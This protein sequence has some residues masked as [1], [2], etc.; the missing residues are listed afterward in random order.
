METAAAQKL[1][2][3][4][5]TRRQVPEQQRVARFAR[6]IIRLMGGIIAEHFSPATISA[7]TGY[8]ELQPVPNLPPAPPQMIPNPQA[9]PH[10]VVPMPGMAQPG[11]SQPQ[12]AGISMAPMGASGAPGLP[13]GGPMP[14]GQPPPPPPPM[15][16]NPAFEQWQ[17]A[18][19]A[20]ANVIAMNAAK[21][22]QFDEAVALIKKDGVTGFR[23]DIESDSTIAADELQDRADRTE[24]IASLL[25]LMQQTVPMAMGNPATAEFAKQLT[26]FGVR[27]FPAARS[28]EESIE[29]F[30]DAI[31]G[32]P[33]PQGK[34][35]GKPGPD[36]QVEHAKIAASMH[37]TDQKAQT[38]RMAIAQRAQQANNQ[39]EIERMK[40]ESE[41]Q[42][43]QVEL[44]IQA[45]E[46]Q[47]R[48][49]V[50]M[51]KIDMRGLPKLV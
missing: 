1:K 29:Q 37:D 34:Q 30:F 3:S 36:P 38:D 21:Q 8:P 47:N 31:G 35:N 51:R 49:D 2:A 48:H 18:A 42:R 45:S 9:M 12:G 4:F 14:P 5:A 11:M 22:Q 13:P 15:I 28:L 32:M 39:I 25:P 41:Q 50:A 40:A 7:I 19:Q 46:A 20:R 16:P 26:L 24:F 6:D 44:A 27:G 10:N 17:K 23:L 43:N 33:P